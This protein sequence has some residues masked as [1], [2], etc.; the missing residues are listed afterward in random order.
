LSA[1]QPPHQCEPGRVFKVCAERQHIGHTLRHV[2]ATCT[3][4]APR[5][6][7]PMAVLIATK[8]RQD[9]SFAR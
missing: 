9:G 5:A 3:P 8:N 1:L 2:Y 6:G 4:Q 7:I